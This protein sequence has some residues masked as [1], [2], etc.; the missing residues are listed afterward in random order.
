MCIIIFSFLSLVPLSDDPKQINSEKYYFQFFVTV[1]IDNLIS[2]LI[3][4]IFDYHLNNI[5]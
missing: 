1:E 5:K 4:Y 2:V 3:G